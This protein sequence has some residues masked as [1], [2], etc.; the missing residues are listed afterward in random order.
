[1]S[2]LS[3]I[4]RGRTSK[5]PRIL[6]YGVEG[7]GK[8]SFAAQAPKPIFIQCEDGLDELAVDRFPLASTYN[9][10]TSALSELATQ[11]HDYETIVVDSVDWLERLV[12]DKLCVQHGVQSIERV[13]GGYGRGYTH[14]VSLWRELLEQLNVLRNT[15]GMVVLLIAHSK[16]ERIEDPEL[17]PFDRFAPRLHRH[18]ASLIGEWCDAIL[19]ATRRVRT[20]TEDSGFG[21]KRNTAHAIGAAGG[22]RVLRCVG[23][24]GCLAKNRYG[25]TDE[26]PL[27]WDAFMHALTNQTQERKSNG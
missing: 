21:R 8:S 17:P 5:P 23:G 25:I 27:R 22:E 6:C 12:W 4:V 9:D 19:F 2:S 1:M 7:V 18:A 16:I 10:V 20:Q 26:L 11:P 3:R 14:A 13:D 15:R 24:P